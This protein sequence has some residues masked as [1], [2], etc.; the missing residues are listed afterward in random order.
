[1]IEPV[2]GSD[3]RLPK[4]PQPAEH[5]VDEFARNGFQL[6]A[7]LSGLLRSDWREAGT[8]P[9]FH[10]DPMVFRRESESLGERKK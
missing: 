9:W 1:M 2:P 8:A 4:S 3:D 6:D 10:R 5:W 7:E